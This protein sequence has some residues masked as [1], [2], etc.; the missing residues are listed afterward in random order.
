MAIAMGV[1]MSE[2]ASNTASAG[3]VV[4][5]AIAI[6]RSADFDPM[7]PALGACLGASFGFMLPIS[8][9]PNAIVYASGLIP[10]VKMMRAGIIFDLLGILLIWG[11][12]RIVGP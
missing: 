3:M 2:L 10:V 5:L 7:L 11:M 12:L 9:P 4:P 1:L 6:A 8:T